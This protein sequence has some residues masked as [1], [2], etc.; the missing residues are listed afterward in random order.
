MVSFNVSQLLLMGP[1]AVRE[2]DFRESLPDPAHEL[3]LR[4]PIAGHARLTRTSEGILAHST[5]HACAIVECARC[6]DETSARVDGT[7][8]EEFLPMTDV[9]T[10]Y[11]VELP[12]G[13]Q[14]DQ[15]LIN[16]HH[17]I[18]L[19]EILRQNILTSLPLQPLC[20][21]NCPGL[22]AE[23]GE[24]LGPEH[25]D[26]PETDAEPDTQAEPVDPSNPFARLAVLLHDD[27]E[28]S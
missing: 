6:L 25:A 22:C 20:Q 4:G 27:E 3:H 26:H 8:D 17:E 5:Y 11:A 28:S 14:D 18:D 19:N 1:G 16:D 9:R 13:T 24:R 7:V 12:E 15:S 23:C 10:G 2:F 21:A